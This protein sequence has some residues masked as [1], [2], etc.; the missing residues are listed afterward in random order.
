ME[1]RATNVPGI[2]SQ[3][4]PAGAAQARPTSATSEAATAKSASFAAKTQ[5]ANKAELQDAVTSG[6]NFLKTVTNA[7][8]FTIDKES[9]DTV[10]KVVDTATKEV[11]R[12]FPSEEMLAIAKALDKIQGLLIKQKA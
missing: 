12:Q 7:V 2:N 1:I 5:P 9:G 10:V 3:S 8:E 6:N 11:V 4:L